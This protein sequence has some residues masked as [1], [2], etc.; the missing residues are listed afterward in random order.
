MVRALL[1][2][3]VYLIALCTDSQYVY[4]GAAGAARLWKARGWKENKGPIPTVLIWERLLDELD[5]PC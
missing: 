1:E 5:R 4:L 3:F 2:I